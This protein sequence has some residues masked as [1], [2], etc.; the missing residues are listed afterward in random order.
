M[1]NISPKPFH[2]LIL[3]GVYKMLIQKTTKELQALLRALTDVPSLAS[4]EIITTIEDI[5]YQ[6]FLNR[7]F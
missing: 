5:L 7:G 4:E 3:I 6:R 2:I 1:Q